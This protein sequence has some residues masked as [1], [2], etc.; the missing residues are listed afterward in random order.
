MKD[1]PFFKKAQY[2]K[3]HFDRIKINR[4]DFRYI[5]GGS[6]MPSLPQYLVNIVEWK[7]FV[8]TWACLLLA[9]SVHSPVSAATQDDIN[10]SIDLG[11]HWLANR[12]QSNGAW[13]YEHYASNNPGITGLALLKF[14]DYAREKGLNPLEEE[15]VY[16]TTVQ[17]GLNY[18]YRSIIIQDNYIY[19]P[20]GSNENY[21][22]AIALAAVSASGN[23]DAVVGPLGSNVDGM[24]YSQVAQGLLNYLLVFQSTTG[25]YE[26]GWS[27]NA[28]QKNVNTDQSNTGYSVL[29][30]TYA[31]ANMPKGFGLTVPD[32][33]KNRLLVFLGNIQNT[34]NG[35]SKYTPDCMGA[36]LVNIL[37]TGS[38]LQEYSFTGTPGSNLS[39]QAAG[40]YIEHHWNDGG[41]HPEYSSTSLGWRDSYQAMFCMMKGLESYHIT[42]LDLIN[43][44][45]ADDDW[46]DDVSTWIIAHQNID[47]SFQWINYPSNYI[48]EG[49]E[50]ANLRAVWALL[51]LEKA[52]P[53]VVLPPTV[54]SIKPSKHRH[55]GKA[56]RAII[57]GTDFQPGIDGTNITLWKKAPTKNITATKVNVG[58]ST[59]LTCYFKIPK[60]AK[61]GWYN[62]TVI[63]PDDKQDTLE[64]GFKVKT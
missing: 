48:N 34:T 52:A 27:Y 51:T 24:T 2:S 41:R 62:V 16:N 29:G 64:R 60:R 33:T 5:G 42:R 55:G 3:G 40:G 50:S 49:E 53:P 19:C 61:T 44:G 57:N 46:F 22:T 15:Y 32:S 12:Q 17:N 4:T 39:V 8:L 43:D 11:L 25:C 36:N 59:G 37:K 45:T 63:N 10:Q 18:L 47:G 1:N 26:G 7:F 30:L 38:L 58:L 54:T 14:E 6:D 56:F 13:Q 35:G 20:G 28:A 23:P 31:Q 21:Y 9:I